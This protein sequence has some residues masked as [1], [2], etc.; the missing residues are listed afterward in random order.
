[1]RRGRQRVRGNGRQPTRFVYQAYSVAFK[2]EVLRHLDESQSMTATL[3]RY[4]SGI[5]GAKKV[6][7][8]AKPV[9]KWRRQLDSLEERARSGRL[10]TQF[11]ARPPGIGLT[12]PADVEERI[13]KWVNDFRCEDS[14]SRP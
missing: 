5:S 3:D 6:I 13:V 11:R 9:Y 1:M 14:Q 7:S 12:L 4:F 2:V 10:A 8:K